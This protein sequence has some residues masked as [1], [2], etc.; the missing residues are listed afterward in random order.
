MIGKNLIKFNYMNYAKR[1]GKDIQ[2]RNLGDYHGKYIC[3]KQ[4]IIVS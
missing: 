2:I 1:G 4:Y 3:S